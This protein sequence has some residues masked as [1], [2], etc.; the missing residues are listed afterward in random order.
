MRARCAALILGL[1]PA[2]GICVE[3]VPQLA[4]ECEACHGPAGVST[5]EDVPSLAGKSVAWLRELLDQF[6]N[7]ERHC[8]TTTYRHGDRAKTPTSMCSVA[9]SLS[10]DDK[11]ALA[12]YFANAVPNV[13]GD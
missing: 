11:Q 12:E 1:L 6:D 4:G 10:D 2:C 8:T 7:Y 9:N 3:D 13:V 5:E